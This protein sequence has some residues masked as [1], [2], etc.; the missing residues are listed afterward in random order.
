ML[1]N[2]V[3]RRSGLYAASRL[4][5]GIMRDNIVDFGNYSPMYDTAFVDALETE[6]DDAAAMSGE[7]T[8]LGR[9]RALRVKLVEAKST[10]MNAWQQLKGYI[11]KAWKDAALRNA[12]LSEAG[13]NIY[14]P[15]GRNGQWAMVN[16][17]LSAGAQFITDN[18]DELL[19]NNN[20]PV[21]FET[22][23]TRRMATFAAQYEGFG[24][25]GSTNEIQSNEKRRANNNVYAKIIQICKDGQRMFTGTMKKQFAFSHMLKKVGYGGTAGI[26]ITLSHGKDLLPVADADAVTTDL[27]YVGVGNE[28]GVLKINRMSEGEHTFIISALGF[29]DLRVTVTLKAGVKSRFAFTMTK[30]VKEAIRDVAKAA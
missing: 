3:A 19:L 24:N 15:A 17:L 6:I 18:K 14:G 8:R 21:A 2:L 11:E 4:C 13:S 7:T 10:A 22:A 12:K 9:R 27:K 16:K 20:M 26:S 28:K 29:D 23:Y 5:C 1:Q 25:A 30:E